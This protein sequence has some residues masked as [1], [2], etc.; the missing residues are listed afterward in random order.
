MKQHGVFFALF[1]LLLLLGERWKRRAGEWPRIARQVLLF[2]A[3]AAI[4]YGVCGLLLFSSGTFGKFWFWT[5]E[6]AREYVSRVTLMDGVESF[7]RHVYGVSRLP[8][9]LWIAAAFGVI[10]LFA[11]GEVKKGRG[12]VGGMLI[13][14]FIAIC[15]GFYFRPHYFVMLLPAIALLVGIAAGSGRNLLE[16]V[17]PGPRSRLIPALFFITVVSI[18]IYREREYFFTMEPVAVSKMMFGANPFPESVQ[19]AQYIKER[20]TPGDTIAV[21]GSEPQIFFYADRI[22]ATGHIYMYGLMEEQKFAPVMQQELIREVESSRPKF[23]VVVNVYT[24]WMNGPNSYP[25]LADWTKTYMEANYRLVGIV[26]MF[27]EL[28]VY[29][30]DGQVTGYTPSSNTFLDVYRR[31]ER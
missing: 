27:D 13:F 8:L 15:P 19:V 11:D 30:W 4:P 24:S 28:T 9:S 31:K 1:A 2:T 10:L 21:L 25:L 29:R 12:F 18:S 26:D 14:S 16:R 22:S 6:Y 5:V 20:S 17:I 3:G 7:L 23:I